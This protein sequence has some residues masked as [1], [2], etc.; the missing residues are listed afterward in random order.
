MGCGGR[1]LR[2]SI[3]SEGGVLSVT[4]PIRAI[5]RHAVLVQATSLLVAHNHPSG[6][7]MPSVP[8]RNAT[9]E[10]LR[11]LHGTGIALIDHLI[12]TGTG[13]AGILA[14]LRERV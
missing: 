2:D 1:L 3:V 11:Q 6:L 14:T 12:V 10:L 9:V 4:I 7:L 5:V 13:C 8:D